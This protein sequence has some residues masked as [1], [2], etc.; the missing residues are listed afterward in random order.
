[1][2]VVIIIIIKL[3]RIC[4]IREMNANV[5]ILKML[6]FPLSI[7]LFETDIYFLGNYNMI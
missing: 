5:N 1:M 2:Y 7:T 4:K 6:H 3:K